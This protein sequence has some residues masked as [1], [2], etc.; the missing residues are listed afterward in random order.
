MVIHEL[1][2]V[3]R[4][5]LEYYKLAK[6]KMKLMELDGWVRHRLRLIIWRQWKTSRTRFNK[7]VKLGVSNAKAARTA[8]GRNGPWASSAS[9]AINVAYPNKAFDDMGLVNLSVQYRRLAS[10]I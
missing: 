7:L 9:S 4:G 6:A 1:N 10:S 2:P 5:W 8:W 3:L